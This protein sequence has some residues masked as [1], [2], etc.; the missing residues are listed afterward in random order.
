MTNPEAKQQYE[1]AILNQLV[2]NVQKLT[3]IETNL[4]QLQPK[5]AK[6][7]SLEAK[8]DKLEEKVNKIYS[9]LGTVKWISITIGI[10]IIIN[11]FSQP[12]VSWL[13]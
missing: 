7:D 10:G 13:F 11:I 3:V 4:Q 8:L 9:T 12:I 6:I 2:Q 5:I 1:G